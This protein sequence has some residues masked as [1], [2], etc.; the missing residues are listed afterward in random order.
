MQAHVHTFVFLVV[1][2]VFL[3]VLNLVRRGKI[4]VRFAVPW[5]GISIFFLLASSVGF[6]YLLMIGQLVGIPHPRSALLFLAILGLTVLV[7]QL[8]AWI[9]KL[10][11]RTKILAQQFA[12]LC[13]RLDREEASTDSTTQGNSG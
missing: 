5:V 2:A 8:F 7:I 1:L 12:L 9:S 3:F 6:P 10:N 13:E 11:E 4:I